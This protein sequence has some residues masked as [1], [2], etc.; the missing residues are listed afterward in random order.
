MRFGAVLH[1]SPPRSFEVRMIRQIWLSVRQN[2]W[3][4]LV[5]TSFVGALGT[6]LAEKMEAHQFDWSLKGWETILGGAATTALLALIHLY[7][8][9]PGQAPAQK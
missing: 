6:A 5:W 9:Q 4:V 8:P 7:I 1:G 2:K 3:F